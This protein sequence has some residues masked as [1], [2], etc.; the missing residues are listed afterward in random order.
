MGQ[1]FYDDKYQAIRTAIETGK[2]Y[3]AT[4]AHLWPSMKLES[5]YARLKVCCTDGG[6]QH[7]RFGEVI[8]ICKFNGTY[9]PLYFACDELDFDRP[10][11]RSPKDKQAELIEAFARSVEES[12]R[13]ASMLER[14]TP[15]LKAVA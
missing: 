2:G 11:K 12:K 13:I 10:A 15:A 6:D 4:A 3:K 9:D 8:Q 5:A 7:L 14:L 1:L